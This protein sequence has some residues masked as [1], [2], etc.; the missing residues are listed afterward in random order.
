MSQPEKKMREGE[1][2]VEVLQK[3]APTLGEGS[4]CDEANLDDR[5]IAKL[6][7]RTE[8]GLCCWP[9]AV[10]YSRKKHSAI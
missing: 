9:V 1:R 3:I 10:N 7:K 8:N 4:V 6:D 2:T 5:A